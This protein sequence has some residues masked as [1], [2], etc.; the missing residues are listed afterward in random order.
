M[1]YANVETIARSHSPKRMATLR[2]GERRT[3]IEYT[4]YESSPRASRIPHSAADRQRG[5]RVHA[6]DCHTHNLHQ[7]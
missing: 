1:L 6:S 5:A 2:R 4:G 3:N 7:H